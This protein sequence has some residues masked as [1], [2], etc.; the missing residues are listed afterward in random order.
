LSVPPEKQ[1][2]RFPPFGKTM[3][4]MMVASI[5]NAAIT[6]L[7]SFLMKI[8]GKTSASTLTRQ[9]FVWNFVGQSRCYVWPNL[10]WHIPSLLLL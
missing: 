9:S 5:S 1:P 10:G 6:R 7:G 3:I 4:Q 2:V 8:Q